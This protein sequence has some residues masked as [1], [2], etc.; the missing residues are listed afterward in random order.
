MGQ[1]QVA[2]VLGPASDGMMARSGWFDF[3]SR[4]P[5]RYS[6][7][8]DRFIGVLWLGIGVW[9]CLGNLVVF[10]MGALPAI[11]SLVVIDDV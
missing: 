1:G 11:N 8:R 3:H 6:Q 2:T 9:R 4:A 10:A 5:I 7:T